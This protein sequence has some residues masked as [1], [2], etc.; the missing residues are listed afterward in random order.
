LPD[1]G[2]ALQHY[3]HAHNIVEGPVL[4]D[5]SPAA[6]GARNIKS[7]ELQKNLASAANFPPPRIRQKFWAKTFLITPPQQL[8]YDDEARVVE[9]ASYEKRPIGFAFFIIDA[10]GGW[11]L[12]VWSGSS[13]RR[14]I[15][16]P[17]EYVSA[18][19]R[20]IL[21]FVVLR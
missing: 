5:E 12:V 17:R 14:I 1:E 10:G 2:S 16:A 4:S 21:R 8:Q 6:L 3:T 11:L 7:P 9:R 20:P 19:A 15:R 18:V 13:S